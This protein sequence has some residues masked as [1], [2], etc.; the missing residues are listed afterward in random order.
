MIIT[1][2]NNKGGVLKTTLATNIASQLAKRHHVC[3]IDFDGQANVSA[4]F[5]SNREIDKIKYTLIDYLNNEANEKELIDQEINKY[6][7]DNKIDGLNII[8][9]NSELNQY[10]LYL[11]N[12]RIKNDRL[13]KLLE[14][15]D[16]LFDYVVID[17]PPNI[18]TLT[19]LALNYADVIVIPFEPDKYSVKGI[20][21]MADVLKLNF[22]NKERKI[23][24]VPT[25]FNKRSRLHNEYIEVIQAYFQSLK[26][27]VIKLTNSFISHSTKSSLSVSSEN[28]PLIFSKSKAQITERLKQ[29]IIDL[30]K[31]II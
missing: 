19:A 7:S 12:G 18:S 11:A 3:L 2:S 22:K 29:E 31:E 14:K 8:Y 16:K 4:T 25:K 23:Y 28:V 17:T 30:T 20:Q 26:E 10:D 6:L 13:K 24:A 9:S 15:L 27:P 21:L 5:K 1:F